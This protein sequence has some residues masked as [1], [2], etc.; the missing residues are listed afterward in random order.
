MKYERLF[1]EKQ[2]HERK[3][4]EEQLNKELLQ[5]D[6]E[7]DFYRK[8]LEQIR[9]SNH[10]SHSSYYRDSSNSRKRDKK[11]KKKKKVIEVP[12]YKYKQ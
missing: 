8:E 11:D 4:R 2:L 3:Q 9:S 12:M 1:I 10:T 6:Q 5:V 7:I